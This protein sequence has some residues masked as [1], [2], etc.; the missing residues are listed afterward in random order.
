MLKANGSKFIYQFNTK[1]ERRFKRTENKIMWQAENGKGEIIR[2]FQDKKSCEE[3]CSNYNNTEEVKGFSLSYYE[4]PISIVFY[5]QKNHCDHQNNNYL[6]DK[7]IAE[8]K[9]V[10]AVLVY[11]EEVARIFNK[12]RLATFSV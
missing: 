4:N 9:M 12:E 3:F 2:T 1:K 5:C 11:S 8:L 10:H 7:R 6:K